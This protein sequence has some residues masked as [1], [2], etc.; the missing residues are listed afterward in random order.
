MPLV[1]IVDDSPTEVHVLQQF[2]VKHGFETAAADTGGDGIAKA[3]D[4]K[5]ALGLMD[6]VMP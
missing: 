2:L 4:L 3:L 5:P 6:E 1:L